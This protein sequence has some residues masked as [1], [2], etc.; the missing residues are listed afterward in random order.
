MVLL[1]PRGSESLDYVQTFDEGCLKTRCNELIQG[2]ISKLEKEEH[3]KLREEEYRKALEE[4]KP[5]KPFHWRELSQGEKTERYFEK[6]E[7]LA[8][9][10]IEQERQNYVDARTERDKKQLEAI[11]KRLRFLVFTV[12]EEE[13]PY[14]LKIIYEHIL[15]RNSRGDWHKK[16]IQYV[17][18]HDEERLHQINTM[19]NKLRELKDFV[20]YYPEE[21]KE[22]YE[23]ASELATL[24]VVRKN[25]E[26]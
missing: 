5:P 21:V 8:E 11:M 18:D 20:P 2:F 4:K 16:T 23:E 26:N 12:D 3:D 6:A 10:V 25:G 19:K 24:E 7:E 22:L 13:K 9:K 17:G 1:T 14:K 15:K